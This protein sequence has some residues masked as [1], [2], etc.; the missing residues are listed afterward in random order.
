MNQTLF[1]TINTI[2]SP[3]MDGWMQWG[4]A[5]GNFWNMPW[6]L[7]CL[8]VAWVAAKTIPPSRRWFC[9]DKLGALIMALLVGYIVAGLVV[10]AL[11]FGLQIPRPSMV[12]GMDVMHS[13]E[14]PD[15]PFS[16]PSGH[17]AFAMLVAATCW[18][19]VG[20]VFRLLLAALVLWI[21][22]S[23]VNLGMHYPVDVLAGYGVGL[24]SAWCASRV[25]ALRSA[26]SERR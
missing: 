8:A 7:A 25:L 6:L 18:R 1:W 4:T 22:F 11:K 17:S 21:G 16:F 15:S 20:T 10:S 19:F 23:R 14:L 9:E 24:F 2:R 13:R 3:H 12:Y 5:L 26:P